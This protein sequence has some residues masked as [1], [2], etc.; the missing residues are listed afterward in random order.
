MNEL[1]IFENPD[2]GQIR[3]VAIDGEPWFVGKDVAE[4]LGYSNPRKAI[5]DHI[6]EEDKTDGVTIRDSIGRE[7][8]PVCI[9]ESGLYSLILSSKLP[10]AKDFKHWVT[11]EVLPSIRRS[12]VYLAPEVNSD[13]MF[14]LA[15]AM[16]DKEAQ[17][18]RLNAK[19]EVQQQAIADMEPRLSYLDTILQ[20]EGTMAS[21]QIAA[22]YG[23]SARKLNKILHEAG[24]QHSVNGQWIL[25]QKHMGKGY[26]KSYTVDI[27]RSDGRPDTK[28]T[29]RWTQKGRLLI[30]QILEQLGIIASMDK[31]QE[32]EK[33]PGC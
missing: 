17:I 22:D 6:D 32:Q 29:T 30:H 21:S 31:D 13:M 20:S 28:L 27:V 25:Y 15:Q 1:I 8:S 33:L 4:V 9:N 11:S 23:M 24:I 10:R 3:T 14:Q 2:F 12:G 26:T 19:V 7:Q 18:S 16:R 5:I